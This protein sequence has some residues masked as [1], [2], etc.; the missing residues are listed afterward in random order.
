MAHYIMELSVKSLPKEAFQ[1][2]ADFKGLPGQ[3]RDRPRRG[4]VSKDPDSAE[5]FSARLKK[6]ELAG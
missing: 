4:P 1:V 5:V 3:P 6:E 2:A